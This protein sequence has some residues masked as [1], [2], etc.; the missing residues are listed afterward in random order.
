MRKR[1]P[2]SARAAIRSWTDG[3]RQTEK[4]AGRRTGRK[5]SRN[6][7]LF[8]RYEKL[9]R[10]A[11]TIGRKSKERPVSCARC[12]FCRPEFNYRNCQFSSC[13]FGAEKDVFRK[14]P[15]RRNSFPSIGF[16]KCFLQRRS[17]SSCQRR[18]KSCT[19]SCSI[20]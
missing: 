7:E 5:M 11:K 14:K 9:T 19:A 4:C 6:E 8:R 2:V 18:P 20:S 1:I 17:S 16:P 10:E 13:P 3:L 15:L 12:S